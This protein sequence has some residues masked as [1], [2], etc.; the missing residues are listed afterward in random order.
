MF[1][2][3]VSALSDGEFDDV[4][5]FSR[6]MS[7]AESGMSLEGLAAVLASA[8][9]ASEPEV[10]SP[11]PEPYAC[12]AVRATG[13]DWRL[14]CGRVGLPARLAGGI[15]DVEATPRVLSI[16]TWHN[17]LAVMR[18]EEGL[19]KQT[20]S[21]GVAVGSGGD[22]LLLIDASA[23]AIL[24][25]AAER[26]AG[27]EAAGRIV[28]AAVEAALARAA[29]AGA[30]AGAGVGVGSASASPANTLHRSALPVALARAALASLI[31]T[32]APEQERVAA[33][34][35]AA[36]ARHMRILCL[37]QSDADAHRLVRRHIFCIFRIPRGDVWYPAALG[38]GKAALGGGEGLEHSPSIY[39]LIKTPPINARIHTEC[40]RT[41][42]GPP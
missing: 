17:A 28:S 30:G 19:R 32:A 16:N 10:V 12:R 25:A 41:I 2:S 31:P 9:A 33:A 13:G 36:F 7:R 29:A 34:A 42:V 37:G 20:F 14:L 22:D 26:V 1:G 40:Q 15:S 3:I 38:A 27:E 8:R 35:D 5:S 6:G 21:R 39:H 24:V 4:A 11:P 18:T 23:R